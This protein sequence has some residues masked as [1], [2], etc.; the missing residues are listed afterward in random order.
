MKYIYSSCIIKTRTK[1]KELI[2]FTALFRPVYWTEFWV[3]VLKIFTCF[4]VW[5]LEGLKWSN[6]CTNHCCAGNFVPGGTLGFPNLPPLGLPF[7]KWGKPK[8]IVKTRENTNREINNRRPPILKSCDHVSVCVHRSHDQQVCID[9]IH[10]QR[11]TV[12]RSKPWFGITQGSR[13]IMRVISTL[14]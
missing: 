1:V 14:V 10:R 4:Q 8:D 9:K 11:T 13:F 3:C 6:F 2:M 7:R 12:P 5:V